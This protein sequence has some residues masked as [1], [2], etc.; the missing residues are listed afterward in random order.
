VRLDVPR[1][2][3]VS[4]AAR[5]CGF[6]LLLAAMFAAAYAVG[7][8]LGPVT[9][10][11]GQPGPGATMHMTGTGSGARPLVTGLRP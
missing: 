1:G 10:T 7:A 11:H 5:L 9:L 8:R 2:G 4:Q 3:K 6:L